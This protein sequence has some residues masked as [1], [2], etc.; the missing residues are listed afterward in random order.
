VR[1]LTYA[2]TA[3]ICI[4]LTGC[5]TTPV[6]TPVTVAGPPVYLPIPSGLL[7]CTDVGEPP[8]KGQTLAELYSWARLVR[9]EAIMCQARLAEARALSQPPK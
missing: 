7:T 2:A 8:S 1:F 5:A 3:G 6:Q 9:T 4:S